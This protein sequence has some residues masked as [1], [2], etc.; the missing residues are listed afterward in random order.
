V[1]TILPLRV[2]TLIVDSREIASRCSILG[3]G[4]THEHGALDL[5]RVELRRISW[6]FG[7]PD[8]SETPYSV[9]LVGRNGK[10]LLTIYDL[11]RGEARWVGGQFARLL[12]HS[13]EASSAATRNSHPLWDPWID[14]R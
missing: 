1:V 10:D 2:Q 7:S 8:G 12:L 4:R 11:T 5:L 9:A 3:I 14:D 13:D 6:K